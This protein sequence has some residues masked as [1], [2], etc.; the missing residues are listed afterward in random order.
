MS[1]AEIRGR[2]ERELGRPVAELRRR[3]CP[4]GS[5]HALEE[6]DVGLGEGEPLRLVLKDLSATQPAGREV[7]AYR[8]VLGPAG[9]D[10]PAC[11]AVSP[12]GRPWL[13]LERVDGVPLWQVGDFEAWEAA[14]RWL[15]RLH[16]HR[17]HPPHGLAA[18][19]AA[20]LRRLLERA[21]ATSANHQVERVAARWEQVVVRLTG[22]PASLVHGDFYPSNVLIQRAGRGPRV[23][24]IDWELIGTGPGPLDLAALSSGRWPAAER[25]RLARAYHDALPAP[26]R[27]SW[28]ELS[29]VLEHARL[30]IAVGWLGAPSEWVPP[31]EHRHD[32]LAD[33]VDSAARLGLL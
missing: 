31:A 12:N 26:A 25:E 6:L 16:A 4:Y 1:D 3:P 33:A 14:A 2:L 20:H 27:P 28:K 15:A 8:D 13:L 18:Y 22:W 19:D 29:D 24:P 32:W 7:T 23:R 5:S 9:L 21:L 30:A 17:T 11:Y 10:V